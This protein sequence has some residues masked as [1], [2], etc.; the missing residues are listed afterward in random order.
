MFEYRAFLIKYAEIGVKGK[1]RFLFEDALVGQIEHS[2]KSVEGRFRVYK[3][4]GRIFVEVGKGDFDYD[5][6]ITALKRV[7]GILSICPV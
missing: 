6:A 1:N 3:Q 2:L 4:P 5:G 7:M